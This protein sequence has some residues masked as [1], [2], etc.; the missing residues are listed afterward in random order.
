MYLTY[1]RSQSQ[2]RRWWV[3]VIHMGYI[4]VSCQ[5]LSC[6]FSLIS[7]KHH[8][9][10]FSPLFSSHLYT[11]VYLFNKSIG[12][13]APYQMLHHLWVASWWL[14]IASSAAQDWRNEDQRICQVYQMLEPYQSRGGKKCLRR[15]CTQDWLVARDS[16]CGINMRRRWCWKWMM[17][18]EELNRRGGKKKWKIIEVKKKRK[19]SPQNR[20]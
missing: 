13:N 10:I 14:L 4:I 5:I 20:K 18:N 19:S 7:C 12:V 3:A 6:L 9:T 1:C 15:I 11:H 16:V 2:N 17:W 8:N